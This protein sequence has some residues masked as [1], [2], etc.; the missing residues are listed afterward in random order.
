[1]HRSDNEVSYL[2]EILPKFPITLNAKITA[3]HKM[4]NMKKNPVRATEWRVGLVNLAFLE[5]QLGNGE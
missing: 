4:E 1:M 3:E 2:Q 5:Q